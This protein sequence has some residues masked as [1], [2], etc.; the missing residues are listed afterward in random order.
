MKTYK[1][2]ISLLL[3]SYLE[4]LKSSKKFSNISPDTIE[5]YHNNAASD[6]VKKDTEWIL[7]QHLKGNI[8]LNMAGDVKKIL[9][10]FHK[11][12]HL[13]PAEQR[14][15]RN[16]K[17][18]NSISD[19]FRKEDENRRSF[20]FQKRVES[21]PQEVRDEA[22]LV[23][24]S[25]A[26][27]VQR[28][29]SQ[30]AACHFGSGTKWCVSA[31][32]EGNM[33]PEY[34]AQGNFYIAYGNDSEGKPHRYG[35]HFEGLDGT[36]GRPEFRNEADVS[37]S[38]KE[39]VE[40]NPELKNVKEFQFK[41]PAL[42]SDENNGKLNNAIDTIE[43]GNESHLHNILNNK[44]ED[45]NFK[46]ALFKTYKYNV[47]DS[48]IS[49]IVQDKNENHDFRAAVLRSGR[50]NLKDKEE[51]L[52][53][54]SEP[55]RVKVAALHPSE[56]GRNNDRINEKKLGKILEDK[57][58]NPAVRIAAL[59]HNTEAN[60]NIVHK[61]IGDK[62]DDAMLRANAITRHVKAED[63]PLDT[64]K[65][66]V[67]DKTDDPIVRSIAI[68]SFG[69]DF[70]TKSII[71]HDVLHDVLDDK[72]NHVD[73]RKAASNKAMFS[74]DKT[75][76]DKFIQDE[77][78]DPNIRIDAM[79][80]HGK[81][82][83]VNYR[84]NLTS[85]L[86]NS[87]IEDGS[88]RKL[89][90]NKAIDSSHIHQILKNKKISPYTK[91]LFLDHPSLDETHIDR[92]IDSNENRL[93]EEIIKHKFNKNV[94]QP[95]HIDKLLD[96]EDEDISS[97][98]AMHK[99]ASPENIEKAIR[100]NDSNI[101]KALLKRKD[102]SPE[103]IDKVVRS[104]NDINVLANASEHKNVSPESLHYMALK[105]NSYY[106]HGMIIKNNKTKDDTLNH[107]AKQTKSNSFL[108]AIAYHNN[109]SPKT[110][111]HIA[112]QTSNVDVHRAI[113]SNK[114]TSDKTLRGISMN[115]TSGD[116]NLR[117]LSHQNVSPDTVHHLSNYP[118][119]HRSI[120]KSSENLPSNVIHNIISNSNDNI[121]HGSAI[122]QNNIHPDTIHLIAQKSV[123]P[124]VHEEIA[125]SH[126]T[127]GKTLHYLA[128][129]SD[130]KNVHEAILGHENVLSETKKLIQKKRNE[131][132]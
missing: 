77:N 96:S 6:K 104:S 30:R 124:L 97:A 108:T 57:S 53:N 29:D 11:N 93:K 111:D 98:A 45:P 69:G 65:S 62:T 15:L 39:L 16:H 13:L 91:S 83:D 23:H 114:N 79:Y 50:V 36:G 52:D 56:D 78:E 58:Q 2:F 92:I 12:K 35:I 101:H 18:I 63:L 128:E 127:S 44:T 123:D 118:D 37:V 103:M 64:V 46:T 26:L 73:V 132:I 59:K 87:K 55:I 27:K 1:Q 115:S 81:D 85:I 119:L 5:H 113:V 86:A 76:V 34:T 117:I 19:A 28:I 66:I 80:Y 74:Y 75:K 41:H 7:D 17:D 130:N 42:T 88:I 131:N 8:T 22:K 9:N 54:N 68:H 102:A 25:G 49:K 40:M 14:E 32:D 90:K 70:G 112:K 122:Y 84:N 100:S 43:Y 126:K 94:V 107:I 99:N 106:V 38:P 20:S 82:T 116:I 21:I 89:Q 51:V 60:T 33:F 110:L 120:I 10:N 109:V 31:K 125:L 72:N 61:I 47:P 24:N 71:P 121:V 129:K 95:R 3:E 48:I 105:S 67:V 4:D